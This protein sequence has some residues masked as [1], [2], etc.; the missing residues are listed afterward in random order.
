MLTVNQ[1]SFLI[2]FYVTVGLI[3][4]VFQ[5]EKRID[6]NRRCFTFVQYTIFGLPLIDLGMVPSLLNM[7]VF[8]FLTLSF[9]ILNFRSFILKRK[10][11]VSKMALMFFLILLIT[12]IVSAF[13]LNSF[14]ETI[15]FSSY[16]LL[17]A[18]IN[19]ATLVNTRT[20][21]LIY[22]W[23]AF[24]A[25]VFFS[26]QVIFGLDFS[27]YSSLNEISLIEFRYTSFAQDP[28]K[29][30][31]IAFMLAIIFLGNF[32]LKSSNR[33]GIFHLF[34]F[35]LLLIIGLFTGS[36]A[37]FF[38]FVISIVLLLLLKVSVKSLIL[39]LAMSLFFLFFSERILSL[40]IFNRLGD[41]IAALEG[42]SDVFWKEAIEIFYHH[43][44]IGIG[45]G[46]FA[47][48]VSSFVKDL[49]YGNGQTIDQPESGY[50]LWLVETGIIGMVFYLFFL[51][52]LIMHKNI[53]VIQYKLAIL[54]WMI[55]FVSVYSFS[56]VRVLY[57]IVTMASIILSNIY[58]KK[59][60]IRSTH[61][62]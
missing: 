35:V 20:P 7:K 41:V 25:V 2:I 33:S 26:M 9:F 10:L 56:D 13:V 43:P 42:R 4:F 11:K 45:H 31:Q 1:K 8:E 58:L 40:T 51:A 39:T 5:V 17:F 55:G 50:L 60:K 19:K 23:M 12:G 34:I 38:G 59:I 18:I 16:F 46:N 61:V 47:V 29:M 36:R 54:V 27:L 3:F 52:K 49:T 44:L 22:E 37:G 48:F 28:Q 21:Q 6:F 57:L 30:A 53:E 32:I 14:Y 24:Y 62:S 15:K